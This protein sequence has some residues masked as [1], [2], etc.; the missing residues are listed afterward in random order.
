MEQKSVK[1]TIL[2]SGTTERR[3]MEDVPLRYPLDKRRRLRRKEEDGIKIIR[4]KHLKL[5]C[6]I[7]SGPGYYLHAGQNRGR[8]VIV[9]VFNTGP[10]VRE[11]MESTVALSKGLM[12]PNILRIEGISSYASLSHF[13][14]YEN[15]HWKNAEGALA[16]ALKDDLAR[17]ITLGFKMIAGL[18]SGM[19]HLSVQRISIASMGN[20][21]VFLDVEDRFQIMINPPSSEQANIIHLEDPDSNTNK[22]WDVFNALCQKVLSSANRM[23]HNEHIDRHPTPATL[24]LFRRPSDLRNSLGPLP[25]TAHQSS[26]AASEELPVAPRR[27]YV[28]RTLERGNQS[29]ATISRRIT[30]DLDIKLASLHRLTWTDGRSV[31]RCPGYVREEITLATTTVDSAVVAHDAPSPGE[32]C[33]ICH[34]VVGLD[35]VFGCVCGDPKCRCWPTEYDQMSSMQILESQ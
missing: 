7:G 34:E 26:D 5:I 17:S 11:R 14:A 2:G 19:N 15:V 27:E 8:A 32:I 33:S 10:T 30:L 35:E 21:D 23:L 18:A 22:S 25:R 24:D 4:N 20:F 16:A 31:H 29:L 13:I 9:K 12:H 1:F 28:W 3:S 6:E